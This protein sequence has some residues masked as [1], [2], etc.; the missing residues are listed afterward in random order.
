MHLLV[1]LGWFGGGSTGFW[2][3]VMTGNA[4]RSS[5]LMNVSGLDHCSCPVAC[6][7]SLL[8]KIETLV[9]F[10]NFECMMSLCRCRNYASFVSRMKKCQK[11]IFFECSSLE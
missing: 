10:A 9:A 8:A 6:P 2:L 11:M 3:Y 7:A 1:V 5:S 4:T